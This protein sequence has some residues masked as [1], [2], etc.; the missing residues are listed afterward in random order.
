LRCSLGQSNVVV[1]QVVAMNTS[2]RLAMNS[3]ELN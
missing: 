3:R 1:G 2:F